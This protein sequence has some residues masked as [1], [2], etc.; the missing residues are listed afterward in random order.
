MLGLDLQGS[1]IPIAFIVKID[2]IGIGPA[3]NI[4]YR[5]VPAGLKPFSFFAFPEGSPCTI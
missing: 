1:I 2:E 4:V 3:V 5:Q